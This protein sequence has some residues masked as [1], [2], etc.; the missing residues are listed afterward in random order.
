[1]IPTGNQLVDDFL[2]ELDRR[3][4]SP[5]SEHTEFGKENLRKT[6]I[7]LSLL[8]SDDP[9]KAEQILRRIYPLF[10]VKVPPDLSRPSH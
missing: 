2:R 9:A 6:R 10:H 1:M 8:M 4:D 5:D 3:I 7:L